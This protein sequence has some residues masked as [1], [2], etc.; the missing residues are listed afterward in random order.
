MKNFLFLYLAFRLQSTPNGNQ[1][2]YLLL[3][4]LFFFCNPKSV[5]PVISMYASL[6]AARYVLNKELIVFK[7]NL[8]AGCQR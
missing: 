7:A 2:L 4:A 1:L 5:G 8:E 3:I 6:P